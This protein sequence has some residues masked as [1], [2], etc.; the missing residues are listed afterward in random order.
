MVMAAL[1]VLMTVT[2]VLGL[3]YSI[4]DII[5]TGSWREWGIFDWIMNIGL[6][7]MSVWLHLPLLRNATAASTVARGGIFA[8]L[9]A[10]PFLGKI[11]TLV[12]AI[13]HGFRVGI[14][15]LIAPLFRK[16]GFFEK[17]GNVAATFGRIIKKHPWVLAGILFLSSF[18]DGIFRHL[19]QLWGDASLKAASIAYDRVGAI[20]SEDGYG[21]PVGNAV[22]IIRGAKEVLPP[23]FTQV[24][25]L[26]GASDCWGMIMMT[27]QYMFLL[28]ALLKGYRLYERYGG[29]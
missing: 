13:Y 14:G 9:E 15:Y 3:G 21:D 20:M 23:C 4:Y 18:A 19:Y 10:I 2:T 7:A 5:S 29:S 25:G 22:A 24:W 11:F 28:A 27:F 12:W 1:G 16:G 26:V 17:W 6:V 8:K